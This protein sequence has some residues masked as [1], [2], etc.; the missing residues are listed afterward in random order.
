MF[1]VGLTGGIGSGKTTISDTFAR[2]GVN[3][4]DADLIA[5]EIVATGSPALSSIRDHFGTEILDKSGNLNRA[6]LRKIIFDEPSQR[7]ILEN[8]T[9][10][11][12]RTEILRQLQ[13]SNSDYTILSAPLLLE[14]GLDSYVDRVAVVDLAEEAQVQRSMRRDGASEENIRAIIAS[15]ISREERLKRADDIINNSGTIEDAKQQVAQLHRLYLES[16]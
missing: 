5:K 12:I 16:V 6:K 13:Q 3:I 11:L 10:P 15:Q 1:V 9:H 2:L 7:K 8:I 4:V 14:N